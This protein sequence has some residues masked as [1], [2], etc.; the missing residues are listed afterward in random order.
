MLEFFGSVLLVCFLLIIGG[1]KKIDLNLKTF[2]K[3]KYYYSTKCR[4]LTFAIKCKNKNPLTNEHKL[5]ADGQTPTLFQ[6]KPLLK[7]TG[8]EDTQG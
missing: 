1:C 5:N 2:T 6:E 8:Y 3:V 4:K 7:H